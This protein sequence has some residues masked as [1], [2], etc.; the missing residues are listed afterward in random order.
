MNSSDIYHDNP[1]GTPT[2]KQEDI[3]ERLATRMAAGSRRTA[4]SEERAAV[5]KLFDQVGGRRARN[6]LA[7]VLD[8]GDTRAELRKGAAL[9]SDIE[10]Y[11]CGS[12][13]APSFPMRSR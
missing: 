13:Q 8:G 5:K 2:P 4:T 11:R 9:G 1:D 7:R 6:I 12:G 3:I 10:Y